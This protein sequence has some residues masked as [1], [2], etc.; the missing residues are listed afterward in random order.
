MTRLLWLIIGAVFLPW[1]GRTDKASTN[2]LNSDELHRNQER[3]HWRS[4]TAIGWLA[5][6]L[7]GVAAIVA[8]YTLREA[9]VAT[10]EAHRQ[11]E[12]ALGQLDAKR[13][14]Q[15]PWV[16]VSVDRV[17]ELQVYPV[18]F[19][20]PAQP[21]HGVFSTFIGS[22]RTWGTCRPSTLIPRW[23]VCALASTE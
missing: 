17:R 2:P 7:S 18:P 5:T 14:E 3:A 22:S 12:A 15:R 16:K 21:L 9:I 6:I 1:R 23:G 11:A 13:R 4:Q 20:P 8:F 10:N 19:F